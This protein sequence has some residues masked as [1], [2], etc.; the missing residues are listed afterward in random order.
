M[1]ISS[2]VW[3]DEAVIMTLSAFGG[4]EGAYHE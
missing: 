1:V 3:Y 4:G 2:R